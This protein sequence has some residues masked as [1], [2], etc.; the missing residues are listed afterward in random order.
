ML[1]NEK[2][3]HLST[4]SCK[5]VQ[6]EEFALRGL[7]AEA[8][9]FETLRTLEIQL[10]KRSIIAPQLWH[11]LNPLWFIAET[12]RNVFLWRRSCSLIQQDE[13]EF[14][15]DIPKLIEKRLAQLSSWQ[16]DNPFVNPLWGIS[17]LDKESS[18]REAEYLKVFAELASKISDHLHAL[19]HIGSLLK[20]ELGTFNP[21]REMVILPTERPTAQKNTP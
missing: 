9:L 7:P 6:H 19:S 8:I 5:S 3:S 4:H 13:F 21:N 18:Q 12:E 17:V 16:E 11:S 1:R 15:V 2:A 20:R 14:W 10:H